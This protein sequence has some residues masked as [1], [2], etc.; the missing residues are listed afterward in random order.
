MEKWTVKCWPKFLTNACARARVDFPEC[1][2]RIDKATND[3]R[4]VPSFCSRPEMR[5]AFD[6]ELPLAF[7][8]KNGR[9][10]NSAPLWTTNAHTHM[11]GTIKQNVISREDKIIL[12]DGEIRAG[13][14]GR[15]RGRRRRFPDHRISSPS[16]SPS[17]LRCRASFNYIIIGR[18]HRSFFQH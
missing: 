6:F 13:F 10:K 16:S 1:V 9:E 8:W 15:R 18:R 12:F 2:S 7:K 14:F 4:F 11:W 17:S 3:T 5:R